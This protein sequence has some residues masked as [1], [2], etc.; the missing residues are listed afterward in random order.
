[1]PIAPMCK[2]SLPHAYF[3]LADSVLP[4]SD[5]PLS[6]V[7]PVLTIRAANREVKP[8]LDHPARQR[9]KTLCWPSDATLMGM[10]NWVTV[11]QTHESFLCEK[12]FF[13][14]FVKV[15]TRERNPLYGT[16]S[17]T[18]AKLCYNVLFSGCIV[19]FIPNATVV[20]LT[21]LSHSD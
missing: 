16:E 1:M 19:G 2:S 17:S 12:L 18:V 8:V 15:F 5:G 20:M 9:G 4:N 7:V 3:Q 11:P 14:Q 6:T 13:K 10:A 21:L